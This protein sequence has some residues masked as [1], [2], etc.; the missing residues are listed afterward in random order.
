MS[1]SSL[2]KVP[3]Y[4]N[5]YTRKSQYT[6][7]KGKVKPDLSYYAK[8]KQQGKIKWIYLGRSSEKLTAAQAAQLQARIAAGLPVDLP[9]ARRHKS[10]QGS[11]SADDYA[12]KDQYPADDW[13]FRKL[14]EKYIEVNGGADGWSNY[15]TDRAYFENHVA[16]FVEDLRPADITGLKLR[17]IRNS[18]RKKTVISTGRLSALQTARAARDRARDLVKKSVTKAKRAQH[19]KRLQKALDRVAAVKDAIKKNRR[20]LSDTTIE[21]AIELI[22]RLSYFGAD[23]D[24]CPGPPKRIQVEA[25]DNTVT[26]DLSPE[27]I[28][29]LMKACDDDPNQDAADMIRLALAT[30]LRRGSIFKLSWQ[31]INF[32]R[33]QI[34]IKTLERGG[35]HSKSGK[36]IHIPMNAVAKKI[37]E[38]RA[39]VADLDASPYV[40]PGK[41]GALRKDESRGVRRIVRAAGLPDS[42]RPLHGLRHAFA[43]NL[44]NT[45][46][47]D[48]Q[49]IGKL[50]AHSPKSPTMTVRYSNV[51][52]D[53]LKRAAGLMS[54][55]ISDATGEEKGTQDAQ[56]GRSAKG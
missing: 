6:T 10:G 42:F 8:Q 32:Q 35:R 5:L 45:G 11:T 46:L 7:H 19:Q 4:I 37:L 50:L 16:P 55:I 26:E 28:G 51:R 14:W 22:R 21:R 41:N 12:E 15:K 44:A 3:G 31:N 2:K 47:V 9:K 24:L 36:Q 1:Q 38:G 49:Q 27:Q 18:L 43:T 34:T 54:D 25:V 52:D 20:T 13:T 56:E 30:G 39:A 29:A 53:A 17:E 23:H 40:F 48:L 33:D